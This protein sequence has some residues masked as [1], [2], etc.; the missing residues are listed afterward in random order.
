MKNKND[1]KSANSHSENVSNSHHSNAKNGVQM[2]SNSSM[3]IDE[4]NKV[5]T[6]HES[7]AE[8]PWREAI[9]QSTGRVFFNFFS[10][11]FSRKKFNFS[12]RII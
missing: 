11:E 3:Y 8:S 7:Y 1:E 4:E 5:T 12:W 6:H 9:D 10:S 2:N